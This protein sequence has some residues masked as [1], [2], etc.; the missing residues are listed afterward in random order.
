MRFER[1][2]TLVFFRNSTDLLLTKEQVTELYDQTE[3]WIGGLRLAA[4]SLQ[5]SDNIA[6][7]IHQFR[8][9]QHHISDYQSTRSQL[10]L[11]LSP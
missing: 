7:F 9:H 5:R 6:E 10:F 2:E 11:F 3:G 4:I 1:D 8:G